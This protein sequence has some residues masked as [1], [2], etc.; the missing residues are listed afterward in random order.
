MVRQVLLVDDSRAMR[1]YVSSILETSGTG[2][3]TEA[4][5]GFDALRALPRGAFDLII[6][7]VNMPDISGIELTRFIRQSPRYSKT[8]LIVISTEGSAVDRER[9][10]AAG[11]WAFV[12]K[13][14][15]PEELMAVIKRV[16]ESQAE[17]QN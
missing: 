10:M 2:E 14:F 16:T 6:T 11:A 8:P 5:N 4:D 1:D 15:S 13:P 7:D 3:I 9:A 12:V 17:N